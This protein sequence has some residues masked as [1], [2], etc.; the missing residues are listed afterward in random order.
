MS[1]VQAT[2][3]VA[4]ASGV[5]RDGSTLVIAGPL[6]RA[7]VPALWRAALAQLEGV[8]VVDVSAVPNVDSAGLALLAELQAR[9]GGR[10][11]VQGLPDGLAGLRDAYRLDAA[12]QPA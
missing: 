6:E 1:L 8:D 2:A 11:V 12:L 4:G 3:S 9:A 5:R 10:L 7:A